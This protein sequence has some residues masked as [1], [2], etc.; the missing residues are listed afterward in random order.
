MI[1]LRDYQEEAINAVCE[2]KHKHYLDRMGVMLPTGT[3]KSIIQAVLASK[4]HPDTR[5]AIVVPWDHL[6][7]NALS[8][9]SILYDQMDIGVVKAEQNDIDNRFVII[10]IQTILREHRL[11]PLRKRFQ[12][13]IVDEMHYFMATAWRTAVQQLLS[14]TG[15]LVGFSATIAREDRKSL[16]HMFGELVYYKSIAEMIDRGWICDLEG[17]RIDA[18]VDLRSI[19]HDNKDF[20]DE[21]LEKI[22]NT[23][24]CLELLYDGWQRFAGDRVTMAFTPT[25]KMA[26]DCMEFWKSKGVPASFVCGAMTHDN[27]KEAIEEFTSGKTQ[28]MFN[29]A[30][31]VVG[32]DHPPIGAVYIIR[33]T[34]SQT[35]FIQMTGRGTRVC[36]DD[37]YIESTKNIAGRVLPK[38][39]NARILY[40]GGGDDVD[41]V[42]FPDLFELPG[43]LCDAAKREIAEKPEKI[44]T[45]KELLPKSAKEYRVHAERLDL[46][47]QS[48]YSWTRNKFGWSLSLGENGLVHIIRQSSGYSIEAHVEKAKEIIQRAE[49]SLEWAMTLAEQWIREKLKNVTGAKKKL[50]QKNAAWR[51]KPLSE[52]QFFF[53]KKRKLKFHEWDS[54]YTY[55][56]QAESK[57]QEVMSAGEA[58]D[59]I[60]A[61][62]VNYKGTI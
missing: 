29:A 56:F 51:K 4:L 52:K 59:I 43:E 36:R 58:A 62:L 60:T 34:K 15:T 2:G 30:K 9:L 47:K 3:G 8:T 33:P 19:S 22:L 37:I 50:A 23:E 13:V 10:S 6:V 61:K 40:A 1:Q 25:V 24:Q 38:K 53:L 32:F 42:Q 16:H 39:E 49:V 18:K 17:I 46:I 35:W 28:I 54:Y 48:K 21:D 41:I 11:A 12:T 20:S 5:T 26:H 57:G 31:L 7:Q 27:A 45:F 55:L 14:D 44:Q